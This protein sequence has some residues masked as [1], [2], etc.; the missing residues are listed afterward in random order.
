M[1]TTVKKVLFE[2]VYYNWS[3]P[4]FICIQVFK[5]TYSEI[6]FSAFAVNSTIK[7]YIK[8]STFKTIYFQSHY[9][10]LQT[11]SCEIQNNCNKVYEELKYNL[12][13]VIPLFEILSDIYNNRK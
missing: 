10:D 7:G 4:N 6:I 11:L 3:N 13:S 2:K 9:T 12:C 8:D 1:D 5:N